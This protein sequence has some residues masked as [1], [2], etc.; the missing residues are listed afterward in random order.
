M[1]SRVGRAPVRNT[2]ALE[3]HRSCCMAACLIS[4]QDLKRCRRGRASTTLLQV[5][6]RHGVPNDHPQQFDQA[7]GTRRA[8]PVTERQT[9]VQERLG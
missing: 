8:R 6:L 9:D 1:A 3:A 5:F 7:R 4:A 2:G